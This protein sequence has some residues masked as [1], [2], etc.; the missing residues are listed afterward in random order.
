VAP[1]VGNVLDRCGAI[2]TAVVRMMIP[3]TTWT[4]KPEKSAGALGAAGPRW[5]PFINARAFEDLV[6]LSKDGLRARASHRAQYVD[7]I[8][9]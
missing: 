6:K 3:W 4:H 7:L 2:V 9:I 1:R 8:Q 5:D